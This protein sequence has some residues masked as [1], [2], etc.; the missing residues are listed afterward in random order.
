MTTSSAALRGVDTCRLTVVGPAGKAD[1]TVLGTVTVG[2]LLPLLAKRV[3]GEAERGQAWTLQRLGG[4]PFDADQTAEML[5]LLD[6]EVLYLRPAAQ[7]LPALEFD[8]ISVG[9]AS[10]VSGRPDKWR[11]ELTRRL[12]LS[13]AGLVLAAYLV[14]AGT[15]GSQWPPAVYFAVAAVSL[16]AGSVLM[17]RLIGDASVAVLLGLAGC[18]FAA[19]AALAGHPATAHVTVV[20]HGAVTLP[21]TVV[22]HG[23]LVLL[24][25]SRLQ[26]AGLC[27]GL[28]AG[29]VLA[30]RR[31]PIA[32]YAAV[33]ALSVEALAGATLARAAHWDA[34]RV[35]AVLAVVTF[36]AAARQVRTVLRAARLR[37]PYPPGNAEELQL[38]IE[39]D[40]ADQVTARTANAVACLNGLTACLA[41][42][43]MVAFARLAMHPQWAGWALIVVLSAAIALR[44]RSV[45]AVWQRVP[46]AVGA[47]AGFALAVILAAQAS[48]SAR[49]TL[50]L[51]V[52]VAAGLL[53]V[54]GWR[55]P[56][57]RLLPV[58]GNLADM[59]EIWTAI[60]VVPLLLQVLHVYSAMRALI[61]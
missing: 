4:H 2:E 3:T 36:M 41:I 53:V 22:T 12:L 55:M 35:A 1:L 59:A 16:G 5:D 8:D 42:V 56:T 23:T 13:L 11:P 39:P 37:V 57:A 52:L 28:L 38:D 60:A 14:G 32:P 49:V 61:G 10:V 48:P 17:A 18:V 21:V 44:A 50:L 51:A 20:Q 31:Q 33:I 54:A 43:T 34:T 40:Q 27:A 46:L 15:I 47:T 6:G 26:L 24:T 30:A 45:V 58:W 9:V 19:A 25:A 7:P 29:A